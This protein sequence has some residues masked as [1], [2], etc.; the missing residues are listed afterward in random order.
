MFGHFLS[1][2][3][4]FYGVPQP[5]LIAGRLATRATWC[6]L[7]L[8]A[9]RLSL[10]L[11]MVGPLTSI[12]HCFD[13]TILFTKT[14]SG[15]SGNHISQGVG[16]MRFVTGA[17]RREQASI[18]GDSNEDLH[19]TNAKHHK[20]LL[21]WISPQGHFQSSMGRDTKNSW[22]KRGLMMSS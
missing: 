6:Y 9:F 4:D 1:E 10:L 2:V 16:R 13:G 18:E 7:L 3:L 14:L 12:L 22:N 21:K 19:R 20:T 8:V 17:Q 11:P 5:L 15:V